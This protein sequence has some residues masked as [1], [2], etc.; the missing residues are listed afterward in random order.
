M[1]VIIDI[2]VIALAAN[3]IATAWF[4]G[5]IFEK[6]RA[7]F[8]ARG[9]LLSELMGCP[10]CLPYHISLWVT[11]LLWL[12]GT[13]MPHWLGTIYHIPLY[14]FAVTT[15][16]HYMQGVLPLAE[17]EDESSSGS[18]DEGAGGGEDD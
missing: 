15:L 16:V 18:I 17:D 11:L 5:D 10:L 9:G 13:F 6:A 3:A 4:Y 7:Y 14:A 12:P 1:D 8:E 2:V